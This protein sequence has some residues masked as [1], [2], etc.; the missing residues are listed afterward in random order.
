LVVKIKGGEVLAIKKCI[1]AVSE[2]AGEQEIVF[3]NLSCHATVGPRLVMK[4][5]I[6]FVTEIEHYWEMV[7]ARDDGLTG[8][9]RRGNESIGQNKISVHGRRVPMGDKHLMELLT[10]KKSSLARVV[11]DDIS[12]AVEDIKVA[13]L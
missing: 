6:E 1:V 7:T 4:P 9:T 10:V 8:A 5:A 13:W 12:S 3:L 2:E 11:G